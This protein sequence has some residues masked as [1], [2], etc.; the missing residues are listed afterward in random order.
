MYTGVVA[1][2]VSAPERGYSPQSC[3]LKNLQERDNSAG[4]GLDLAE[5]LGLP[6]P[7]HNNVGPVASGPAR[8]DEGIFVKHII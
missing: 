3:C 8:R 5:L 6:L 2:P 7:A 4:S 1:L